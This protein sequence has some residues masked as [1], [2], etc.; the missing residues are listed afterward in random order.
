M[1]IIVQIRPGS[2]QA[3]LEKVNEGQFR[4]WVRAIPEKGKANEEMREVLADHFHVAKSSIRILIGK[5]AREKLVE[6]AGSDR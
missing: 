6:I 2:R 5:T 4:V 3:R 1:K